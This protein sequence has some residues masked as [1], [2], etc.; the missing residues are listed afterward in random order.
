MENAKQNGSNDGDSE[1]QNIDT[2]CQELEQAIN[3][4]VSANPLTVID[5]F[6]DAFDDIISKGKL[7]K[8]M[9]D[10][11]RAFTNDVTSVSEAV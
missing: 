3:S 6:Q 4:V 8:D 9:V 1:L 10:A 2:D 11:I 5:F 7:C